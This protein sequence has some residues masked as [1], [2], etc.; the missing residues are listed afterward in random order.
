MELI[1][2]NFLKKPVFLAFISAIVLTISPFNIPPVPKAHAIEVKQ[3]PLMQGRFKLIATTPAPIERTPEASRAF[4]KSQ[5]DSHGWQG[6]WDCLEELWTRESNWRPN[7]YN[8]TAVWSDGEKV[9]AGGIPQI[10]GLDPAMD[11]EEQ[12]ARGF[13]YIKF[14][15]GTP[16]N[17]LYYWNKNYSY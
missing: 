8:S 12:I 2:R 13:K 10:L 9:H 16:C 11:V 14:R 7:A 1:M 4:A 17:A 6:Q 5:L 3:S 15:Y